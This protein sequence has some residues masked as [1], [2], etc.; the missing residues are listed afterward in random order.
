MRMPFYLFACFGLSWR[1]CLG[2]IEI[3]RTITKQQRCTWKP[4][5]LRKWTNITYNKARNTI[6]KHKRTKVE[7]RK[8]KKAEERKNERKKERKKE[9]KNEWIIAQNL[10]CRCDAPKKRLGTRF[11]T[12]EL[13]FWKHDWLIPQCLPVFQVKLRG[14]LIKIEN[15]GSKWGRF[16]RKLQVFSTSGEWTIAGKGKS[17]VLRR[18]LFK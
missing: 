12:M 4:S 18:I 3:P 1:V 17:N 7:G 2:P 14:S 9:R 13:F 8:L 10:T 6:G 5:L 15:G 16:Y 11:E